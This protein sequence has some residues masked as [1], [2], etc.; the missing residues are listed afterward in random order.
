LKSCLLPLQRL[1]HPLLKPPHPQLQLL[2]P[3]LQQKLH[4]LQTTAQ[5]AKYRIRARRSSLISALW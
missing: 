5:K 3:R 2:K 1:K 4:Q